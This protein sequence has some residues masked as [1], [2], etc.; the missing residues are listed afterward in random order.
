MAASVR[1]AR[2]RPIGLQSQTLSVRAAVAGRDRAAAAS[3]DVAARKV[4]AEVVV[5]TEVATAVVDL[6]GGDLEAGASEGVAT[7]V[8]ATVA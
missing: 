2:A 8:G 5:R 6:G 1:Q 7:V 4:V 3:R